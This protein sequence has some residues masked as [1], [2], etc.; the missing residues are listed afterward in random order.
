[1]RDCH[2]YREWIQAFTDGFLGPEEERELRAHVKTCAGCTAYLREMA[3]YRKAAMELAEEVPE[4]LHERIM[5]AYRAEKRKQQRPAVI[6]FLRRNPF[7]ATAAVFA[8]VIGTVF[9]AGQLGSAG[10]GADM[11]S[12]ETV[13]RGTT[14]AAAFVLSNVYAAE[15]ETM[16]GFDETVTGAGAENQ[17]VSDDTVTAPAAGAVTTAAGTMPSTTRKSP[18]AD[19]ERAAEVLADLDAQADL[20]IPEVEVDGVYGWLLVVKTDGLPSKVLELGLGQIITADVDYASDLVTI[21]QVAVDPEDLK[22]IL[23]SAPGCE[24]T[25]YTDGQPWLDDQIA[26][27]LVMLVLPNE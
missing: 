21:S 10:Y 6:R 23:D 12:A 7:V 26:T 27:G 19:M 2:E 18:A 16:L 25:L 8:L 14:A 1:M 3:A 13:K 22:P 4:G 5:D 11:A 20:S 17:K 15:N 24:Y 9:A